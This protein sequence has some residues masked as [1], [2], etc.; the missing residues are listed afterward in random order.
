MYI[1]DEIYHLLP[2]V[3]NYNHLNAEPDLNHYRLHIGHS[4]LTR[5]FFFFFFFKEEPPVCVAFY[6]S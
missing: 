3:A 1:D 5:S 4:C 6:T 2:D